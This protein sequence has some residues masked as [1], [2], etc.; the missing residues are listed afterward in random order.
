MFVCFVFWGFF[1]DFEVFV[2][3]LLDVVIV[4]EGLVFDLL[5]VLIFVVFDLLIVDFVVGIFDLYL[6]FVYNNLILFLW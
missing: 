4:V 2:F 6:E 5:F 3:D 1:F